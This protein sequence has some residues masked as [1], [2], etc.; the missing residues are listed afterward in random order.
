MERILLFFDMSDQ[1]DAKEKNVENHLTDR[2]VTCVKL[3][4][5][6]Q[7][8]FEVSGEMVINSCLIA[9][10]RFEIDTKR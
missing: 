9:I 1:I 8:D 6:K 5:G 4:P 10:D 3:R 7:L 2:L